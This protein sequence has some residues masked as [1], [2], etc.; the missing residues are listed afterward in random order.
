MKIAGIMQVR[1]YDPRWRAFEQLR[2]LCDYVCVL[3]NN[4]DTPFPFANQCDDYMVLNTKSEWNCTAN[5]THLLYQSF[6]RGCE[7]ALHL[8]DDMVLNSQFRKDIRNII[9]EH[10]QRALWIWRRDFWEEPAHVRIDGHWSR[11]KFPVL[12]KNWFFDKEI[13]LKLPHGVNQFHCD[14]TPENTPISLSEFRLPNEYRVYHA[15]NMR[16]Q[17]RQSRVSQ[18]KRIDPHG[19]WRR[20]YDYLLD[21]SGIE[22]E[23]VPMQDRVLIPT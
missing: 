19:I 1:N 18:L 22:L 13:T 17:D 21:E 7:W 20:N 16:K 9:P 12:L 23:P 15:G 4:S 3:D 14:A 2:E 10:Q 8:D 11:S 6:V 5:L